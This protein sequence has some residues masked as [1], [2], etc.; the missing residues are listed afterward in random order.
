MI[1]YEP[2]YLPSLLVKM[3]TAFFLGNRVQ[4]VYREVLS[5]KELILVPFRLKSPFR[6]LGN[7]R[8]V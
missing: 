1:L 6:F 3:P 4:V 8:F 5:L 7:S 2:E